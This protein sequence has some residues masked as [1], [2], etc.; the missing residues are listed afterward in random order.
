[1]TKAPQT[2]ARFSGSDSRSAQVRQRC[3]ATGT[4]MVPPERA[5]AAYYNFGRLHHDA[6]KL[7]ARS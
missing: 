5:C 7:V 3:T 6:V 2:L 4:C 1:M